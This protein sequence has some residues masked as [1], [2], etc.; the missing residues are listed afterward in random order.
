LAVLDV[1]GVQVF[2]IRPDQ[3]REPVLEKKEE[4]FLPHCGVG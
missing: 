4:G 1:L 2:A 3:V